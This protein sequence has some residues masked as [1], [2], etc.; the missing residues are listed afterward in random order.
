[1]PLAE[2]ENIKRLK[3]LID[4]TGCTCA[5]AGAAA[6]D[7]FET[8]FAIFKEMNLDPRRR[9]DFKKGVFSLFNVELV[10]PPDFGGGRYILAPNHVS[11][12][13]AII[14]GLLHPKI[15]IVSKNEWV[16]N[17]ELRRFLD[18]HYDLCG[19][20]RHSLH[21]LRRLMADTAE[22]FNSGEENR[23]FL[24]FCQGTISDFNN[25][26]LERV[27]PIAKN[28]SQKTGVPVV[29]V[30]LEQ[31]SVSEPTRIVFDTPH[32]PEP[33]DDF[34]AHWL[35]R[36]KAM[37]DALA[38]PARRPR[39]TQKHANNNKPGDPFF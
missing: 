4:G 15:R 37:Q 14:L 1:M 12:F 33:G 19:I 21:S 6:V 31:P 34:R 11:D 22:Y 8:F 36:E 16:E 35:G 5:F 7:C 27:S 29:N 17:G 13:D 28:I 23:H 24:V 39:L 32:A 20:D 30:Y 38:P 2:T 10:N 18:L 3:C 9:E 26:A 25:N